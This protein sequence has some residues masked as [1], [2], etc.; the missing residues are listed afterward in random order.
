MSITTAKS[1]SLKD[2]AAALVREALVWDNVWPVDLPG[3]VKVGN[4]WSRLERFRAAGVN[5]IGLTL[6]GD[7]HDVKGA[8]ELVGWARRYIAQNAEKY[9]LV[10]TAD[11]I[12]AARQ[13]GKIAIILQFEGMRCFDRNLDLADVFYKLG[14]RQ[15]ILAFNNTNSIGGG[16]AEDNDGG[17]TNLGRLFVDELQTQGIFIDLSHV[18]KR[19]SL[20]ALERTTK[21]M[22]FTH[23]NVNAIHRSF[24]NLDDDQIKAAAASGGL[25]GV[26]GSSEYLG[27]P[28]CTTESL[29]RHL[30][31]VV[32][33]VGAQ[34]AG[35]GFDVVFDSTALNDWARARPEEWPMAAAADWPGFS[36]AMPEQLTELTAMMLGAGYGEEATRAILGENYLRI[37]RNVWR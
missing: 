31:Y 19:T 12:L 11:D 23:S 10:E 36:Y 15:T 17:L 37:L 21:P 4:D 22:A 7:N 3:V 34:H 30:D 25:V 8:I 24:R 6:A 29:F 2:E 32:E 18:G 26:S 20:E 13:S 28:D 14:V 1:S 27:D 33:L 5:A 9:L 16:C 35:I